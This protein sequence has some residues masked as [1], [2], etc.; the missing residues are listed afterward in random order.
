MGGDDRITDNVTCMDYKAKAFR[1]IQ[2]DAVEEGLCYALTTQLHQ[3]YNLQPTTIDVKYINHNLQPTTYCDLHTTHLLH[4]LP[5]SS[6]ISSL[7]YDNEKGYR[8]VFPRLD[9]RTLVLI[10]KRVPDSS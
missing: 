1:K 6:F 3:H 4:N 5:Y 7:R 8:I 2:C 9:L 10:K